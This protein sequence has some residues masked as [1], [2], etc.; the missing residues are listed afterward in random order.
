MTDAIG[1]RADF[2]GAIRKTQV[3]KSLPAAA[4]HQATTWTTETIQALMRSAA[5]MQKSPKKTGMMGRNIGKVITVGNDT[6]TITI[7]TGVGGKQTVPY[8]RIQDEG[9]TTKAHMIYA[10]SGGVLAFLWKGKDTFLSHVHHPGSKI[11]ASRWFTKVIE[12]RKPILAGMM[13][14]N[15]VLKVAEIMGGGGVGLR[16]EIT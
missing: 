5:A 3:L 14:P 11:P 10:K 15:V 9:G 7:G 4:K 8:A 6:W 12:E 1:L 16:S 2:S 13:Q